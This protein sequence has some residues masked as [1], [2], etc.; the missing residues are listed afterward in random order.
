MK[1]TGKSRN[2]ERIP[3]MPTIGQTIIADFNTGLALPIAN[4][5]AALHTNVTSQAEA[6]SWTRPMTSRVR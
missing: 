4:L 6:F 1:R 3:H 5:A 2:A